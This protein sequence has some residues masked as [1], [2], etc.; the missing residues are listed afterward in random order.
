MYILLSNDDKCFP[1]EPDVVN[2]RMSFFANYENTIM[3]PYS[4]NIFH[5]LKNRFNC[6]IH[7]EEHFS[8]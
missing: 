8:K 5:G 1:N 2:L 3:V 4:K 7:H 6:I